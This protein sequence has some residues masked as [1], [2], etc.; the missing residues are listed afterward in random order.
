MIS[1]MPDLANWII[2]S[3]LTDGRNIIFYHT[4]DA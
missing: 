3:I 4:L 2:S 1:Q